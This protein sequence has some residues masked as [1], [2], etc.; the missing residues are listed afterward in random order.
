MGNF[1]KIERE[2]ENEYIGILKRNCKEER[3]HVQELKYFAT[4]AYSSQ[5]RKAYKNQLN[6]YVTVNCN[7]L[8]K[9]YARS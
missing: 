7:K 3:Y 6:N 4:N 9:I 2:I 1:L 5:M 8:K